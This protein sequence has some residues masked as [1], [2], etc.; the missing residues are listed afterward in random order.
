MNTSEGTYVTAGKTADGL[1]RYGFIL[2]RGLFQKKPNCPTSVLDKKPNLRSL[3]YDNQPFQGIVRSVGWGIYVQDGSGN[4]TTG[5][6]PRL[7]KPWIGFAF[8]ATF[9][10]P[11]PGFG[12]PTGAI[13]NWPDRFG[14]HDGRSRATEV[15]K[16]NAAAQP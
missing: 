2:D 3:G 7:I 12:T 15:P 4:D 5:L 8:P 10:G 16:K 9:P 6:L 14:G 11:H 1:G 13:A